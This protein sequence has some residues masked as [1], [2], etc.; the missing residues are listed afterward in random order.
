MTGKRTGVSGVDAVEELRQV[1]AQRQRAAAQRVSGRTQGRW[2]DGSASRAVIGGPTVKVA[3]GPPV[4]ARVA[5]PGG[6]AA[7]VAAQRLLAVGRGLARLWADDVPREGA[8]V[9]LVMTPAKAAEDEPI[10]HSYAS[11]RKVEGYVVIP[12]S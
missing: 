8:D 6:L 2:S 12:S 9:R 4:R 5:G 10:D 3:G 1:V 7:L 11:R